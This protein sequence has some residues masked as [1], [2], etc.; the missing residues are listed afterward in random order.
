[1]WDTE[2]GVCYFT[3]QFEQPVRAVALSQG[4]AMMCISSDPF[5]GV[6]AA[7]HLVKVAEDRE[8]Q[9]NEIDGLPRA[10]RFTR[11]ARWVKWDWSTRTRSWGRQRAVRMTTARLRG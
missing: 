2:T 11:S 10:R 6:P 3:H 8:A 1:M 7:L 4:D 9:T 5:M